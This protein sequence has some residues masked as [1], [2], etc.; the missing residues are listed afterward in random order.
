MPINDKTGEVMSFK[1]GT[2]CYVVTSYDNKLYVIVNDSTY[3][4]YLIEQPKKKT[5]ASVNGYKPNENHP[6]KKY[7]SC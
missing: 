2:E 4:L 7:K 5:N 3:S 1:S 6:W